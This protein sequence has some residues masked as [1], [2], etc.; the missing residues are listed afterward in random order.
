MS[1]GNNDVCVT[2]IFQLL[3]NWFFRTFENLWMASPKSCFSYISKFRHHCIRPYFKFTTTFMNI[4]V[5][6]FFG[7]S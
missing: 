1:L 6:V 7:F 2:L 4:K 3:F 5:K